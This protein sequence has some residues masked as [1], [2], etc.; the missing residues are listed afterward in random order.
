MYILIVYSVDLYIFT[1]LVDLLIV[2]H[3]ICILRYDI[4]KND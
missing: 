1:F 2:L 3:F 4:N